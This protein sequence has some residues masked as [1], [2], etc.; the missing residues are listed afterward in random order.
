MVIYQVFKTKEFCT[1]SGGS[2]STISTLKLLF[3]TFGPQIYV[4]KGN[5]VYP[6]EDTIE[7]VLLHVFG[8]DFFIICGLFSAIV[9]FL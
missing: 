2:F 4:F 1:K 3:V 8:L 5:G 6:E 9:L 7:I